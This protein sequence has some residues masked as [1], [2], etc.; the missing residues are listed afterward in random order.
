MLGTLKE[1]VFGVSASRY[2]F[3]MFAEV[4]VKKFVGLFFGEK[5]NI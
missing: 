3:A 1:I 2:L 5:V 4:V